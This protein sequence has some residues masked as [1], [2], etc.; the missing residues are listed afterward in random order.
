[1]HGPGARAA[2]A[3]D[4]RGPARR[5]KRY[6]AATTS[7]TRFSRRAC[8]AAKHR[9]MATQS[10][11]RKGK[12]PGGGAIFADTYMEEVHQAVVTAAVAMAGDVRKV[13][14]HVAVDL[15]L[16]NKPSGR[17]PNGRN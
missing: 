17:S 13:P 1:M 14:N 10:R 11:F 2:A 15:P 3:P 5:P 6:V 8:S 16:S 12:Q 4:P 9:A 7:T